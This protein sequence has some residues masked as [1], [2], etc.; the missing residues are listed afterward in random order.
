MSPAF[1]YL[2]GVNPAATAPATAANVSQEDGEMAM[3]K[4][5]DGD[6]AVDPPGAEEEEQ[7]DDDADAREFVFPNL[8]Q[9]I[10]PRETT[11]LA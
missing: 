3:G 11:M 7:F 6:A 1:P 4:I 9:D 8:E 5:D 2:T 10:A